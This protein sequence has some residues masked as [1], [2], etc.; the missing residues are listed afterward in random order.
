MKTPILDKYD[1]HPFGGYCK[2]FE[3]GEFERRAKAQKERWAKLTPEER[4]LAE[5]EY[6][7]AYP[8]TSNQDGR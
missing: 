1:L 7:Y 5:R 4:I 3:P 6:D 2:D 8:R